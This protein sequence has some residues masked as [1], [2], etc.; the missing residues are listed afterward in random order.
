MVV[1]GRPGSGKSSLTER[2]AADFDFALVRSGELLRDA[3]RRGD[4]VGIQVEGLLRKGELAPDDLVLEVL[5]VRLEGTSQSRLLFDGFPRTPGQ[6]PLLARCERRFGFEI[7]SYLLI[8]VGRDEAVARMTGRRVC[9]KCGATYHLKSMPPVTLGVCD[10]DGSLLEQR[11]DDSG[12]VIDRRQQ[13]FE[14]QSGPVLRYY[15]DRYPDRFQ[16]V[17]GEQPLDALYRDTCR[18]LGLA[19]AGTPE[20]A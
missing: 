9:P 4:A 8:D 20:S 11:R 15:R 2:L 16:T 10:I 5:N 12:E 3:S 1:F 19:I 17:E 18:A 7:D 13:I 14:D 6:V